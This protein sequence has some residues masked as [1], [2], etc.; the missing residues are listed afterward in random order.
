MHMCEQWGLHCT[1]QWG[2][3]RYWVSM[4]TVW[5]LHSKWL[6]EYSN[7]SASNFSLS[8]NI[9]PWKLFWWPRRPQLWAT[10]DGQLHHNSASA[11]ASRLMQRFLEKHQITQVTQPSYSPDL[12]L[13]DFW[14]FPKLTSPLKG[15]RSQTIDEIQEKRMGQLIAIERPVWGPKGPTLKGT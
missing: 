4:C 11:H 13:C 3:R 12:A 15:K 14:L 2:G 9:P 7:E 6:S 8:M 5:P 1:S 10:G